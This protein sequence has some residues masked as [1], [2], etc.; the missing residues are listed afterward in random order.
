M[1]AGATKKENKIAL[2]Y[3]INPDK[4]YYK[5]GGLYCRLERDECKLSTE[6]LQCMERYNNFSKDFDVEPPTNIKSRA[7]KSMTRNQN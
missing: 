5:D 7:T 6:V 3:G 1:G 4:L 2:N